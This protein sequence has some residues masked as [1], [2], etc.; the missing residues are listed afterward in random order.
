MLSFNE[1]LDYVVKDGHI[2]YRNERRTG[3]EVILNQLYN[4]LDLFL[5]IF[6]IATIVR[7]PKGA[8]GGRQAMGPEKK[9][10]DVTKNVNVKFTDVAGLH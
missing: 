4:V 7:A 6:I 8:M 1:I 3:V 2:K 10:F 9:K 5:I